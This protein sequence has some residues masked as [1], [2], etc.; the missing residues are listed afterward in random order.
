VHRSANAI[1]Q[2][3]SI[4]GDGYVKDFVQADG[5][6]A[7]GSVGALYEALDRQIELVR[8]T[9]L[10]TPLGVLDNNVAQLNKVDGRWSNYSKFLLEADIEAIVDLYGGQFDHPDGMGF[11]DSRLQSLIASGG[12]NVGK[13]NLS[14]EMDSKL[15]RLLEILNDVTGPIDVMIAERPEPIHKLYQEVESLSRLYKSDVK[16]AL[17][18]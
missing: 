3:W 10:G 12:A 6:G 1:I 18:L 11:D 16:V 4:G 14:A 15:F 13:V 2:K 5:P 9:R 7:G 17:G 8:S